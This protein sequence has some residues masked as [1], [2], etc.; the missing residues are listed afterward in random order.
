MCPCQN[1]S[2]DQGS[3]ITEEWLASV[4]FKYRELGERQQFRHWTLK[5]S[6]PDDYGLEIETTMPGW[7]N[8]HGEHVGKDMGWF[9]WL[10]RESKF[11]HIRHM[12]KR[13]E[14]IALVE[15]LA[16]QP[17]EPSKIGLVPVRKARGD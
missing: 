15:A 8:S 11:L 16:G 2:A 13:S 9:V 14:M 4:G 6:E 3:E 12:H 1:R 17:W 10:H 5:F 7:I